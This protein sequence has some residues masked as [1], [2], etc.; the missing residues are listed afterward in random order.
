MNLLSTAGNHKRDAKT[1]VPARADTRE[2][3]VAMNNDSDND[4]EKR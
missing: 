3:V 1:T 4:E 2:S